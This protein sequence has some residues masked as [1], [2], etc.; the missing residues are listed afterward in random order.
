MK[1]YDKKY[2]NLILLSIS[3]ITNALWILSKVITKERFEI[4]ELTTYFSQFL[5]INGVVLISLNFIL[6]SRLKFIER[7]FG[8]LDKVYKFHSRI[9]KVAF[10][11]VW[12]HPILL[13]LENFIGIESIARYFLP[14]KNAA[15]NFGIL[16]LYILTV[17]IILTVVVKLPYE[18]WKQIHKLML[19][20][21]V[22]AGAHINLIRSDT[23]AFLPLK[24]WILTFVALGVWFWIYNEV[25]YTRF[26]KLIHLYKVK[27]IKQRGVITELSLENVKNPLSFSAGQYVL[28][29]F[30]NNDEISQEL[31]PYSLSSGPHEELRISSKTLGNYSEDLT[32][33][34]KGDLVKLIGPYGYFTFDGHKEHKKQLWIAGGIG[35]TPFLSMLSEMVAKKS[36]NHVDFIYSVKDKEEAVYVDEIKANA[37]KLKSVR[38]FE[39]YS[40]QTGFLNA[41]VISK[42]LGED[43]KDHLVMICGPSIMMYNL[44]KS[45]RSAGVPKEKIVFEDFSFK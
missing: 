39:H 10:V 37:S 7:L 41:D 5:A 19:F 32:N 21:L 27:S 29:S 16:S 31:H 25:I 1:P 33:V 18:I 30:E 11:M 6:A 24:I 22:L 42:M 34:D 9:G 13:M 36:S 17:L 28:M 8:G 26:G 3:V 20:T 14:G 40:D 23:S 44:S 43:L 12:A 45:L 2:K 4:D 15:I 38:I 35:V